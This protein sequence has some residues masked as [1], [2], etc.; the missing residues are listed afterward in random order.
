MILK[1]Y[2][3]S[4]DLS[5]KRIISQVEFSKSEVLEWDVLEYPDEL[6]CQLSKQTH[7]KM[8][9][10]L[11]ELLFLEN[12]VGIRRVAS[13][14]SLMRAFESKA[15]VI[16]LD[17]HYRKSQT[18]FLTDVLVEKD[19]FDLELGPLAKFNIIGK[20]IYEGFLKTFGRSDDFKRVEDQIRDYFIL[21]H[22]DGGTLLC[23]TS[24]LRK[25]AWR[26]EELE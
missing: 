24:Y 13:D 26:L 2:L 19:I 17:P 21:V 18:N 5:F 25:K 10:L 15:P 9:V 8:S 16:Y 14:Y 6:L 3:E 12:K 1:E 7:K 20:T 22:D 23:S 11:Y 4:K